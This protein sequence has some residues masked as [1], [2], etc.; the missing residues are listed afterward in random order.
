LRRYYQVRNN[1]KPVDHRVYPSINEA[2]RALAKLNNPQA[3]VVQ[4]DTPPVGA[5]VRRFTFEE[6]Q[7]IVRSGSSNVSEQDE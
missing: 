3:E 6:C 5:V 4:L 7:S 1:D 2:I